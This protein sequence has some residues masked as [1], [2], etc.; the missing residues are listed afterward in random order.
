[1]QEPESVK[2]RALSSTEKT[3]PNLPYEGRGGYPL[4]MENKIEW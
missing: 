4:K 1:V 2:I 3:L